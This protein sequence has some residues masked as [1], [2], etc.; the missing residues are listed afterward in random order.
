MMFDGGQTKDLPTPR[1]YFRITSYNVCYTKLLRWSKK[2]IKDILGDDSE[3]FCL[4]FDV[5]EGG[6]WEGENILC[7]NRNNFV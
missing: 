5:T 3:L 7:N 6:N 2:E 4:F 1:L